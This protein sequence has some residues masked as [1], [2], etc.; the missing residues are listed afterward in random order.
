MNEIEILKDI[1]VNKEKDIYQL[2]SILNIFQ[3]AGFVVKGFNPE[4]YGEDFESKVTFAILTDKEYRETIKP[5]YVPALFQ[6]QKLREI[7]EYAL[8][9][10][11][12]T[13][14]GIANIIDDEELVDKISK[15]NNVPQLVKDYAED[16]FK[17]T[18]LNLRLADLTKNF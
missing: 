13:F 9:T 6:N 17:F 7:V 1:I 15:I 14:D 11:E 2:S 3:T 5:Y 10:D 18:K 12:P 8:S 16:Q 4:A